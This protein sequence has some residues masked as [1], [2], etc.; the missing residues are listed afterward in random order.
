V[1]RALVVEA[2]GR[3]ALLERESLAPRPGEVVI[4]PAFCGLCGTDIEL[5]DGLV[6]P[7]FVRYPLTLGHEWSGVVEAVGADVSGIEAGDRVVAECIVPCGACGPCRA[8]ATNVCTTYAELGFTREGGASE[9]VAVP[10]RLVHV[11]APAV[12]LLDAALVEPASVVMRGLEKATPEPGERVLV[13]G[14]GTIGLL[15]AHLAALWSPAEIVMLGRRPEQAAL[16]EAVGATSFTT[17]DGA[18]R[19]FDLVIEAAGATAAMRLAVG[20]ARRGGRVL[21]LGLPPAGQTFELP[22][23]LLVNNDLTV[24]A[25]FGYTSGAWSRVVQLL[26]SARI[27]PGQIVTHRFALADYGAAFAA[28]AQAEGARGKVMLEITSRQPSR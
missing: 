14:D 2:P 16:A 17:D 20:A 9:Q 25:S 23:D 8:G 15:A 12:S 13:I 27:R 5:R 19:G 28:L 7:A 11:L 3:L 4:S 22:A 6:D 21:L 10:A 26:S 24:A 18:A 1:R